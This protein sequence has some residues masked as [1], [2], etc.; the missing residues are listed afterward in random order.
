MSKEEQLILCHDIA[1]GG[2]RK[3]SINQ[4]A[5]IKRS[6]ILSNQ[7]NLIGRFSD[8]VCNA[9][10]K[11][12]WNK[13]QSDADNPALKKTKIDTENKDAQNI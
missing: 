5:D 11:E 1:N 9:K 4:F 13:E 8:K 10:I 12:F 6:K 2:V 3:F 7:F